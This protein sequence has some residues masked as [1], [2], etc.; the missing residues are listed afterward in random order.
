[1]ILFTDAWVYGEF[2]LDCLNNISYDLIAYKLILELLRLYLN[3]Y[4]F[5]YAT[6]PAKF[7]PCNVT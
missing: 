4:N 6:F 1:M 7:L 5:F 3:C 2:Y